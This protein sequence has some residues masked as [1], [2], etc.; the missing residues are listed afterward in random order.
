M[1]NKTCIFT[2]CNSDF[3]AQ[4]RTLADSFIGH[5]FDFYIGCTD[6]ESHTLNSNGSK[7]EVIGVDKLLNKE[8]FRNLKYRNIVEF[9]TA[10]KPFSLSFLLGRGYKNIFYFDP[11]IFVYNTK[12]IFDLSRDSASINLTP[13]SIKP[14]NCFMQELRRTEFGIYNLGF[15]HVKNDVNG[16]ELCNWWKQRCLDDC[17]DDI[18]SGVFTDQKFFDL[19]PALFDNVRILRRLDLNLAYWNFRLYEPLI[20]PESVSFIHW[21]SKDIADPEHLSKKSLHGESAIKLVGSWKSMSDDYIFRLSK[22]L[23]S[24]TFSYQKICES[25]HYSNPIYSRLVSEGYLDFDVNLTKKGLSNRTTSRNI[26]G[27]KIYWLLRIII[28]LLYTLFNVN[29]LYHISRLSRYLSK[30]RNLVE[31]AIATNNKVKKSR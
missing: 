12:F 21:S 7:I 28:K 29:G 24:S 11:D 6:L 22:N 1:N 16:V 8:E 14:E 31:L 25:Y 3:L 18:A 9:C 19:V 26:Q 23:E 10:I 20:N 2:V 13:H 27:S 4:A 15:L 30:P 17:Y 5:D